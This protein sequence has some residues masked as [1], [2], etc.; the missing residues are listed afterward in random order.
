MDPTY[1]GEYVAQ[2]LTE[3]Y[4]SINSSYVT[5]AQEMSKLFRADLFKLGMKPYQFI[6]KFTLS[7]NFCEAELQS[8]E[9]LATI[10]KHLQNLGLLPA[11]RKHEICIRIEI[12]FQLG[13]ILLGGSR[14]RYPYDMEHERVMLNILE[15]IRRPLYDLI[16]RRKSIRV[17][18]ANLDEIVKP[19]WWPPR[20]FFSKKEE[21]WRKWANVRWKTEVDTDEDPTRHYI[22]HGPNVANDENEQDR[23]EESKEDEEATNKESDE[24][25][26]ETDGESDEDEGPED[27]R[28]DWEIP[29]Q[30]R[31]DSRYGDQARATATIMRVHLDSKND[32]HDTNRVISMET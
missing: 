20:R 16:R 31:S 29:V 9:E 17:F 19:Q 30:A 25:E 18:Q 26:E 5:S 14:F 7:L 15:S 6:R 8:E 4:Y 1:F 22:L 27:E 11:K 13:Q 10:R 24:D 21:E 23:D 3:S 28:D 32:N 2:E 12:S